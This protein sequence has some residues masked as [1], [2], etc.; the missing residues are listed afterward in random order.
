MSARELRLGCRGRALLFPEGRPFCLV[1]GRR[2]LGTRTL[3]FKDVEYADRKTQVANLLLRRVHPLLAW[4]NR[5]RHVTFRIDAPLC[6]RHYWRGRILDVAVIA[7]FLAAAAAVIGLG[8][9]GKLPRGPSDVGSLLKGALI[10]IVLVPGVLVWTRA[11]KG[12]VLP[13]EVRRAG[14][15]AI[16]LTYKDE[17]SPPREG[18]RSGERV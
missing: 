15:D 17:A 5:S 8:L 4:F 9:A 1:C 6:L 12:P 7:L 18:G 3:A 2:P 11:R 16:V 14:E 10:A 13:C